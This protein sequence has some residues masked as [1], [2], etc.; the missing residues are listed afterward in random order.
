MEQQNKGAA[1]YPYIWAPM[2]LEY[3][4][5]VLHQAQNAGKKRLYFLARDGYQMYLAAKKLC[6]AW[7]IDM[8]CRYLYVSRYS[9]RVPEYFLIGEKCLDRICIGGIDVTFAKIM[10]RAALT[11]EEG[12]EI[13]LLTGYAENYNQ[14]LNYR[15]I[16]QLKEKLRVQKEFLSCVYRHSEQAYP[17][18]IGYLQQEGLLSEVPYALVDSGWTGT[19]QQTIRNLLRT[20]KKTVRLEGY[21][22]GLYELPVGERKE[23]YRAFYFAPRS[24]IRRKIYFSN[25]LFE[26]VLSAPDGMTI[27]YAREQCYVPVL[28]AQG[29]RNKVQIEKTA[30]ILEKYAGYVGE[31]MENCGGFRTVN[32][33]GK[34]VWK[35]LSRCMGAPTELE[36]DAYGGYLFS[37]DV[38]EDKMQRLSAELSEKEIRQQRFLGRGLIMMGLRRTTIHES[39]WLEGSITAYG[40]HVKRNLRH[41]AWYKCIVYLRKTL[42]KQ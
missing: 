19:L 26:A 27:G 42:K 23:D 35:L 9:V 7:N 22:F 10:K 12:R 40:I 28:N 41:A 21:Y 15:E 8:E 25:S 18:A 4:T 2:L 11:E 5:W 29:N 6:A 31:D 39:A 17:A 16:Q 32:D 30:S 36:L 20:K 13:A 1:L 24:G 3:V 14:V 34:L 37:D 38:R 33:H